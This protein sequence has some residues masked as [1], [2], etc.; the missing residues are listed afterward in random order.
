MVTEFTPSH[1]GV[2]SCLLLQFLQLFLEVYYINPGTIVFEEANILGCPC[3]QFFK[4][5]LLLVF[6]ISFLCSRIMKHFQT[7]NFTLKNSS[8]CCYFFYKNRRSKNLKPNFS[9][10]VFDDFHWFICLYYLR[11]NKYN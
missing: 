7:Q 8:F 6:F 10:S 9:E 3:S 11:I 2:F 5:F 4:T 1:A